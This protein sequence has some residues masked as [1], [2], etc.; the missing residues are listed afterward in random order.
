MTTTY[1]ENMSQLL[2]KED[3]KNVH[4]INEGQYGCILYRGIKCDLKE[5]ESSKYVTKIQRNDKTL[6][7]ELEISEKI[8]TIENVTFFFAPIISSCPLELS[9]IENEEIRKCEVYQKS[10]KNN[11]ELT[12]CKIRFVGSKTLADFLFDIL[13]YNPS[14][15]F[16]TCIQFHI[17]LLSSLLKLEKL[18]LIHFDIKENNIMVDETLRIPIFIDFGLSIEKQNI[19]WEYEETLFPQYSEYPFWGID[20]FTISCMKTLNERESTMNKL[21]K[22]QWESLQMTQSDVERI[23]HDFVYT[24]DSIFLKILRDDSQ[25]QTLKESIIQG[26][27]PYIGLNW[28]NI[29]TKMCDFSN[30]W[31]QYSLSMTFLLLLDDS[32][33]F[34]YSKEL[35]SLDKYKTYLLQ[36]VMCLPKDRHSIK[37]SR[38][39]LIQ[40]FSFF[41]KSENQILKE[42]I[43]KSNKSSIQQ[44]LNQSKLS[45]LEYD[46][47]IYKDV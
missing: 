39:Y 22:T 47:K 35:P 19:T 33:L 7:K 12:A 15:F 28:K 25:R 16:T 1:E 34:D 6:K 41:S 11:Q 32:L 43:Y 46:S 27:T 2:E 4:R 23:A 36:Q 8:N 18:D 37:Q 5:I 26:F 3:I 21:N 30:T 42:N 24:K 17:Y 31:D 45:E 20:I 38:D 44:S 10:E 9:K 13:K 14:I 29:F 40:N